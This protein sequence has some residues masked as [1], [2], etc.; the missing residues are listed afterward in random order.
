MVRV[1]T[2]YETIRPVSRFIEGMLTAQQHGVVTAEESEQWIAAFE[3][4]IHVQIVSF[5]PSHGS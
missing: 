1:T 2:D 5:M 4:T 3:E